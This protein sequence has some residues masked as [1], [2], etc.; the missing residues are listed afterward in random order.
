M[1]FFVIFSAYLTVKE[2]AFL[3]IICESDTASEISF[4]ETPDLRASAT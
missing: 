4:S 2:D 3:T 1:P